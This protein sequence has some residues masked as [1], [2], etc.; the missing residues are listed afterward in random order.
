MNNSHRILHSLGLGWFLFARRYWGNRFCFL[1]P[2]YWDVSLPLVWPPKGYH[3]I[4]YDRFTH[5]EIPGS[6]LVCN[7]PGLIAAYHVFHRLLAP[8]HP[9]YT[10]CNLT[11]NFILFFSHFLYVSIFKEQ[12]TS[13]VEMT[14][15]EPATST[16]Q[17]WRSP[18]WATP[19][20]K[21]TLLLV[22][23]SW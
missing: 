22:N 15:V 2:R 4:T 21:A 10:L 16:V 5:S 14:G 9:S 6:T 13:L 20:K 18:N 1:F 17:V 3:S 12:K 7:F 8:R 11:I 23:K 19:P